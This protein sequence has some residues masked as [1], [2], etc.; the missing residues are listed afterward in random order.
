VKIVAKAL[1]QIRLMLTDPRRFF[2]NLYYTRNP[3]I[4][5][6][7]LLDIEPGSNPNVELD[8]S[9]ANRPTLNIM[10]PKIVPVMT[11]G[12]NT[13]LNLAVEIAKRGIPIRL[14]AMDEMPRQDPSW[15]WR[16]L[17]ELS[18]GN[19][20][21]FNITLGCCCD[22]KT[23]L[24]IG[25]NDMFMATY[26]TT[27]RSIAQ[28]LKLTR[29]K[30]FIYLLQ[31]FEPAFFAWSS[32]YALALETYEMNFRAIINE[33]TLADYLRQTGF[34]RFGVPGFIESGAVFE[35]AVDGRYFY[36]V[37][38]NV[39]KPHRLLFYARPGRNMIGLG[40][41]ALYE[42]TAHAE[43]EGD[44]EFVSIGG[45]PL[46]ALDLPNKRQLRPA[47]WMSYVDY[48]RL[49][50]ES[51]ILL[52]LMLSPH[53]SYPALEMVAS[54]GITVTNTYA[55]KT[56]DKLSL[57]SRNFIAAQP[58][59]GAIAGCLV[60]A[61]R[62]VVEGYDYAAPFAMPRNWSDALHDTTSTI[63]EVIEGHFRASLG[64]PAPMR[65]QPDVGQQNCNTDPR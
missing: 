20:S 5:Q 4:Y 57:I 9:L 18:Q 13:A 6:R 3:E 25:T 14:V 1:G 30:E 12:P 53:T 45:M 8:A 65:L 38:R 31:D 39:S 36:N 52:C 27:A 33:T 26:W 35:P 34:G 64:I 7:K 21:R 42:A 23:P 63:C 62:R 51:D 29:I 61:A 60:E 59:T 22:P 16:H 49:V 41:E 46:P 24:Q 50:R 43:F 47:S 56:Q 37:G 2:D 28:C 32:N 55:T 11:G 19:E 40:Y 58:N 15:F 10:L 44:W 54:G 17:E 48:A